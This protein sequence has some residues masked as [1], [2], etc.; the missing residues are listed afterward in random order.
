MVVIVM[1][2]LIGTFGINFP[3]FISTMAIIEFD[4]ARASYGLLSSILAIGSVTGA[5]LSARRD[6]PPAALLIA[7]GGVLRPRARAGRAHADLPGSSRIALVA[8]RLVG[9][10]VHDHRER[11]RAADDRAGRCAAG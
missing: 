3:I 6:A 4:R 11:L 10:D 8:R 1:V 7:A 9:A 5:L 2:F